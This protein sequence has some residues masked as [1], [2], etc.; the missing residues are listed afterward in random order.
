MAEMTK[1]Q[2][3]AR[4]AALKRERAGYVQDGKKDRV[5]AVDDELKKL[6]AEPPKD[7]Q[8]PKGRSA[9][10]KSTAAQEASVKAD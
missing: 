3:E 10:K 8:P 4:V 5:K 2:R 1:A 9:A 7:E 6:D